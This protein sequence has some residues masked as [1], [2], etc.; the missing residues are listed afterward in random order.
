M[1]RHDIAFRTAARHICR[2][3]VGCGVS[4]ELVNWLADEFVGRLVVIVSD[5]NVAPLHADPL[6]RALRAR[7]LGVELISFHAGEAHKIRA[8]KSGLE[9]QLF[10]LG[11]G[12]DT[13][14]VAVG[15]GVT[16]DLAGFIAA[17]WHR[18]VPVIQVP[19]SLLAMVDAALGGKT[20]VDLPGGK[21]IVGA[22]H[23]PV[24]LYADIN[25]LGTLPFERYVEG[26]AEVVKSAAI[27]DLQL[28]RTL[29]G[30]VDRLLAR[31]PE[32]LEEIVTACLRIKGRVVQRDERESGRRAILNFG[33]T[34]AH[35]LEAVSEFDVAHGHA[36][37]YGMCV[38]GWLAIEAVEF[39]QR[40]FDRL[41]NLLKAVGL[42]TQLPGEFSIQLLVEASHRDKKVR[43]GAVHYALPT[44]LGRM[45]AGDDVTVTLE[46]DALRAAIAMIG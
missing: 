7:G 39:P 21:N 3:C 38:E 33:H 14:V 4:A 26:L 29:E 30:S 28:F 32:F 45:P 2:V 25:S 23:Q 6:A 20:A 36:V 37:A 22:F 10:E 9:D 35:A 11:A 42:P 34:V 46:D 31:D 8:T 1:R 12:R 44:Q 15:G 17:T 18:G 40:H 19:T 24:G 16:G 41:R 5:S 27:A 13:V 43:A